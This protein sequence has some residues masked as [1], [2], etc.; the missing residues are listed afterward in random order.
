MGDQAEGAGMGWCILVYRRVLDT[1]H[2]RRPLGENQ[3]NNEQEMAQGIHS[4][5]LVD[6]DEQAF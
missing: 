2:G 3:N 5:I 4:G 6:L 1:V